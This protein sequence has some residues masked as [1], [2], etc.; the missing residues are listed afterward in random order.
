M[1]N[2]VFCRIVSNELPSV[3]VYEDDDVVAFLDIAPVNKGHV[4]VIPKEHFETII[5]IPDDVLKK[6]IVVVK[7]VSEAVKDALKSDGISI[8]MSNYKAAGQVI[9]HAHFH[10]IPR[11]HGD[12][13]KLWSQGSYNDGEMELFGSKIRKHLSDSNDNIKNK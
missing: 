6:L 1:E 9:P 4:L 12:G 8:A 11:F 7:N 2:C 10:I 13:L 5:D 3:K